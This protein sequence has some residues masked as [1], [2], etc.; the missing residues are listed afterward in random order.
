MFHVSKNVF[1]FTDTGST[2]V[3]EFRGQGIAARQ[4][5]RVDDCTSCYCDGTQT[6][7]D[8]QNCPSLDCPNPVKPSGECCATCGAGGKLNL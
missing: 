2:P 5:L 8:I 3:C 7:C 6:K 1:K 4:R